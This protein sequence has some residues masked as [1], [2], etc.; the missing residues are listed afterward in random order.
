MPSRV[1]GGSDLWDMGPGGAVLSDDVF[2]TA[3]ETLIKRWNGSAWVP[4]ALQR[5]NGSAWVAA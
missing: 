4:A 5:W 2:G 3:A 1:R